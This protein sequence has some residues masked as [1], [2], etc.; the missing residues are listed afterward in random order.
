MSKSTE[1]AVTVNSVF[2]LKVYYK[3]VLDWSVS[4]IPLFQK[5]IE[6]WNLQFKF[7]CAGRI[8]FNVVLNLIYLKIVTRKA[9]CVCQD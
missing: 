3:N 1:L 2:Q 7:R 8:I 4:G 9:Q 5:K 6:I